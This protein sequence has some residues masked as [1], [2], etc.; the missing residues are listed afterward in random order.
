MWRFLK[1]KNP[2]HKSKARIVLSGQHHIF[3]R[4]ATL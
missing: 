3:C 2:T 4:Q 1:N